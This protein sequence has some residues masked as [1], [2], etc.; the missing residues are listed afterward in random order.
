MSTIKE[1]RINAGLSKKSVF[2]RLGIPIRT[3]EDWEAERRSP[4]PWIEA[5]VIREYARISKNDK[6]QG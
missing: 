6:S 5:M 2:E 3:Q 1:A 4:A